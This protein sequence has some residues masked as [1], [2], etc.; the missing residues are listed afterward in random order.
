M[1]EQYILESSTSK[2][3][4]K[5]PY[6]ETRLDRENLIS[7]IEDVH[8]DMIPEGYTATRIVFNLINKKENGNCVI[9][10]KITPWNEE[11]ARYER[12]CSKK[13]KEKAAEIAKANMVKVYGKAN[14]LG[15]VE[16]QQKMLANRSISGTYK[17]STGGTVNYTGSYERNLLEFLDKVMGYRAIDIQSPGPVIEYEFEG[18]KHFWIT[19]QYLIP[20]NLVFDVKDGGSNPNN[21]QMDEY[22]AKQKAKEEAI[23]KLGKYNYIRLTNNDFSQL[24]LIL[25][26]LKMQLVDNTKEFGPIIRINENYSINSDCSDIIGDTNHYNSIEEYSSAVMGAMVGGQSAVYVIPYMM[27]NS[28]N[29]EYGVSDSETLDSIFITDE[30]G[31]IKVKTKKFIEEECEVFH[32]FK[33]INPNKKEKID[34]P[35]NLAEAITGKKIL[36][37][38]QLLFDKDF[39]QVIPFD[40]LLNMAK[41]S[42]IASLKG[43]V[44]EIPVVGENYLDPYSNISYWTDNNGYFVKNNDTG[45]RSK[46]YKS[47]DDIPKQLVTFIS[48][49]VL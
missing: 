29:V 24:M 42:F 21:R 32:I 13:C 17:F 34:N 14:L 28:F 49:G 25:A 9:C 37:P 39:E 22:R 31:D 38:N 30:F 41:D 33:F 47:I 40:E 11:I 5:C 26:E 6:C 12:F 8:E 7:H 2:K 46:S 43:T 20:Y 36:D 35:S 44:Y 48:E 10:R 23:A 27:K 15:D 45:I 3:K 1:C 16:H 19:D 18:K 4:F